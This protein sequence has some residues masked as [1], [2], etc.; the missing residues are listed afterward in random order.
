MKFKTNKEE[1][2]KTLQRVQN[3]ISTKTTL[4]ILSNILV[5]AEKKSL[6][7]TA[8]DL[9]IGISAE[10]PINVENEGGTTIPAKKFIDII[11]ELPKD[12]EVIISTKKN[13]I[14]NI[15]CGKIIFKI[16]GLPKD[17]FP[18][19]PNFK[20]KTLITTP[21]KFLK[22]MISMTIFAVSN[23]ETRYVLNGVLF[24]IKE[25]KIK[26]A[27]TDGRRLAVIEKELPNKTP[28][29]KTAIIPTKTIQ[30][31]SRLLEESGNVN[32]LFDEN[33]VL[34]DLGKTKIISRL[35]EGEFP[36]YEQVI[37]KETKEKITVDRNAFLAAA[38]RASILTNPES[39]GIKINVSK[40]KMA[41]SKNT[42]YMGEVRE[43]LG[44]LYRGKDLTVGFNPN[45]IIEVLKIID[46]KEISFELMDK[47]KPGVI[48]LGSEYV[49]VILPMQVI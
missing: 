18:Q 29:E 8:T 1:M 25:K 22:N 39:M 47:D 27:A 13:N 16:V 3:A 10:T 11:K 38:R 23:D 5:E 26:L 44:V 49:Y 46:T 20:N 30:E 34:F 28:T 17:E 41:I 24:N 21:Q 7:I 12:N 43:D 2:F 4:P 37:P 48:R 45:Y 9:D 36:N 15:E 14:T 33:Q 31:L 42:P 35:I 32:I 40:N 6:K 19:P